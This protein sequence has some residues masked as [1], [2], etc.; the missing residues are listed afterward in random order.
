M[1]RLRT[2]SRRALL[3]GGGAAIGFGLGYSWAPGLSQRRGVPALGASLDAPLILNDA[4]ELSAT[5]IHIHSRPAA[6]GDALV[7]AFRAELTAARAEERPVCVSAA[8]H[9]MGGQSLPRNGHAITVDDATIEVDTA[10]RTY[11]VN[12]GARWRDVIAALD[13]LGFSPAVM[14]SNHDFGVAATFSVNAHGWPVPY[15]PM[16]AT[17]RE[18]RMVLPDGA[19]VTASRNQNAELFNLAVGGYGLAGLIVDLEVEMVPN[20]RLTPAFITLPAAEFPTAF[21]HAVEDPTIPM[22]YGRLNVSRD[23]FFEEALLVTYAPT[24]DQSDLPPAAESG[25]MSYAAS[26]L[27]RGQVGRESMKDWRW[28]MEAS[29]APRVAGPATRNTLMNEPVVTLDDR[30]PARV[31]ILHEYFIP[32]DAF[33]SFLTACREV[34][35]DAFVEFL[36][37]TLRFVDSDNDSLLPHSPT[38]R[39]AAVMSFTQELT[40]R[41]EADHARM[42][43]ALIDRVIALG[44]TYYLPYRPHATLAQFTAAYPRAAEFAE[45]KRALDPTLT[46]RNNL[47]DSYLADL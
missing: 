16:G 8:R 45:A 2:F 25:W 35:P 10:R 36:N 14:Q 21:R 27:Y 34:I 24:P 18:I 1:S 31:D 47:W 38:P 20:Q 4:S 40:A 11:R 22:A 28:W 29:L 46:L 30:D 3:M 19:L 42:T 17:V 7:A 6:H 23:S 33:D 26:Y 44:G 39:I 43:R 41:A 32:F 37:V 13:P 5:P 12:G 15:G 9:S